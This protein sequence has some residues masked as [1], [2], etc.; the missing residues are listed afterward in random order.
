ME[1]AQYRGWEDDD[2]D[3]LL[4]VAEEEYSVLVTL[5][6]N[7]VYQQKLDAREIGIILIDIHAVFPD[8]LLKYMDLL[9][10]SLSE[11]GIDFS[12]G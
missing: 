9:V 10:Q 11:V 5:D 8:H 4:D 2:D 3:H 12:P 7:L 1:T 6:I